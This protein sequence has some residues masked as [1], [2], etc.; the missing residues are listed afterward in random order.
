MERREVEKER[1]REKIPPVDNHFVPVGS[2]CS[3]SSH[4]YCLS[5]GFELA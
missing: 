2:R 5:Y 4:P 3:R 1:E